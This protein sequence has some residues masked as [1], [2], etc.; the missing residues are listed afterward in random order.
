MQIELFSIRGKITPI[1]TE[2]KTKLQLGGLTLSFI[3]HS[4]DKVR[5]GFN[6]HQILNAVLRDINLKIIPLD[7]H[8]EG[9]EPDHIAISSCLVALTL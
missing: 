3:S 7:P 5:I 9:I 4:R 2:M 1:T 6:L 8:L